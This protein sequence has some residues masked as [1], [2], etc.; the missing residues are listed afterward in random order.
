MKAILTGVRDV[1]GVHYDFDGHPDH[2]SF[3]RMEIAPPFGPSGEM[4]AGVFLTERIAGFFVKSSVVIESGT[5]TRT[6]SILGNV[7]KE[8]GLFELIRIFESEAK[9]KGATT[10]IIRGITI[11]NNKLFNPTVAQRLGYTF[12]KLSDGAFELIKT[13]KK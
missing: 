12:K 13:L 7:Q 8:K 2:Y 1:N 5:Y 9:A 10:M 11:E 6:I 3:E 4:R